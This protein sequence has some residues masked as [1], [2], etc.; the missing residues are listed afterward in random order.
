MIGREQ[1]LGVVQSFLATPTEPAALVLEGSAG[2][3]KTTL[4]NAAVALA[5]ADGY[6]VLMC[7]P[8]V[9]E[10]Q[11]SFA[12]VADLLADVLEEALPSLP[13]PQRH[14][15]DVALLLEYADG[16]APGVRA[17]AGGFLGVVRH[18]AARGPL[19][20]AI[21]D[22]Q[23]I[24]EPSRA[25]LEFALRRL[26]DEHV[27]LLVSRRGSDDG[28]IPTHRPAPVVRLVLNSRPRARRRGDAAGESGRLAV[29]VRRWRCVRYLASHALYV[30]GKPVKRSLGRMRQPGSREGMTKTR[31]EPKLRDLIRGVE[32]TLANGRV[33]EA[34]L[35]PRRSKHSNG[36]RIHWTR[37]S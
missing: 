32:L 14:A 3:G 8:A 26:S 11:L 18:A 1:E 23:W 2:I 19:L 15:L 4:W 30:R 29:C 24:D 21:D 31:A 27:R 37:L 28:E 33:V 9:A 22:A 7:R 12:A 10:S 36:S 34:E 20:V 6:G 25:V 16:P 17:I 5:L 35:G 13:A